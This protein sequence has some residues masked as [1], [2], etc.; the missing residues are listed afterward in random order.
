MTEDVKIIAEAGVNHNGDIKLA[1]KMVEVAADAG[2]DYIKFQTFNAK[3]QVTKNARKAHY[4]LKNTN[5]IETQYEMLS[6]LEMTEEMHYQLKNHA[7]SNS[8]GFLSTGFD[9]QSIDF[10]VNLGQ[11]YLKVPSGEIT[12]LPYLQH[13]AEIGK[14]IILS[15][16]M[17]NMGEIEAALEILESVRVSRSQI[18]ILH[19]TTEY[20]APAE[21]VNLKAINTIRTAFNVNVGYSDHTCGIEIAGAAVALGATMIEKHFTLDRGLPGPDHQASLEPEELKKMILSIRNI[22]LAMGDGV[23]R[24][25]SSEIKNKPIIRKSLVAKTAISSGEIFTLENLTVKR[26]GTG[27]SPMRW[28]EVVGKKAV[29]DFLPEDLIEL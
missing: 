21:E 2:A 27:L 25:S 28:A 8:I 19:C 14:P 16:G 3:R 26:P 12:N 13:I 20:P 7:D 4:Q 10:L 24:L 6:R 1:K 5:N 11:D 18:T 15:T 22:E 9:I 17:A 29:R 23:K